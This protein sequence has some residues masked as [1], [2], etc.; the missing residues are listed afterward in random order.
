MGVSRNWGA[1][2]FHEKVQV[3]PLVR[4]Q[5]M[6]EYTPRGEKISAAIVDN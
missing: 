6:V 2:A 3:C 1:A 5:R 4:L